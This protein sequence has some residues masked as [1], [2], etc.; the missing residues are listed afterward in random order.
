MAK[1]GQNIFA[2]MNKRAT[3]QLEILSNDG[4]GGFT[5][6]WVNVADVWVGIEAVKG[7]EKLQSAQL[8]APVDVNITMRY[9]NDVTVTNRLIYNDV[10][11][12]IKEVINENYDNTI[13]KLKC[14]TQ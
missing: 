7:Y 4:Q 9:R 11:F 2:A 14:L 12:D 8:Q 10:I 3:L 1:C 6:N 5:S 13:L